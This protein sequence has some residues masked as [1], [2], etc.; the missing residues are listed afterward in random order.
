MGRPPSP[1]EVASIENQVIE[2]ALWLEQARALDLH[3]SD[4]VVR[5]RLILNMKFLGDEPNVPDDELFERAIALGM[6]ETDTVVQR[7]L[8]DRVQALIR[9]GVRAR[10]P[11][12]SVLRSHYE[13]R[14]KRWLQPPLIDLSH[15]YFSRDK[16]G[17]ETLAAAL[18][19]LAKLNADHIEPDEA[20]AMADPFLSGHRFRAATPNR[21]VALFG[22]TFGVG[23]EAGVDGPSSQQWIGPIDSAFGFHLLWIHERIGSRLPAFEEIRKRVL[24][25]WITEESDRALRAQ[26]ERRRQIVEVRIVDD[27]ALPKPR[28]EDPRSG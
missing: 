13:E 11:D 8:I 5:Q 25:D 17:E 10:R 7:R 12:E 26:I 16:R 28:G 15:V 1:I 9:A 20:T 21:I 23:V 14:A 18:S 4:L 22:P 3:R 27:R 6:D 19:L 24:E 2:D